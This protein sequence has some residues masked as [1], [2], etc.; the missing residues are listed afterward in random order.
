[1]NL[2]KCFAILFSTTLLASS[3]GDLDDG[4]LCQ[5]QDGVLIC[6]PAEG[7]LSSQGQALFSG[8]MS[9]GRHGYICQDTD[10]GR[11]CSCLGVQDCAYMIIDECLQNPVDPGFE[12]T[13]E[14]D[15]ESCTCQG[16]PAIHFDGIG[17]SPIHPGHGSFAAP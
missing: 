15:N 3:C 7:D 12:C 6:S 8:G 14:G 4:R 2:T 17:T 13:G 16:K 5:D 1:M 9:S 10:T 11:E